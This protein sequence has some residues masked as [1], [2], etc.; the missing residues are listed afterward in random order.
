MKKLLAVVAASLCLA[1]SVQ[2]AD[3]DGLIAQMKDKDTDTRRKAARELAD[4]GADAKPAL[5][6]LVKALTSDSDLFVRRFSAQAIGAI[7]ED[8]KSALPDL[9]KVVKNSKEKPEVQE[10]AVLAMGKLG[11]GAVAF[12]GAV[13]K[14]PEYDINLRRRAAEGLGGIGADAK[15][16]LPALTDALKGVAPKGKKM[17]KDSD[18]RLEAAD[19]LG[20]I[21]MPDDK[22]VL[23]ALKAI[24]AEKGAKKNKPLF[25]SINGAVKKIE[26]RK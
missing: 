15:A 9:Q 25:D 23:E 8:A 18:I 19:A 4:A 13:V 6:M 20:N 10:A 5:P 7:G 21:A 2:A 17:D 12:L 14:D 16:A 22:D 11:K 1:V 3:V 26:A 24:N